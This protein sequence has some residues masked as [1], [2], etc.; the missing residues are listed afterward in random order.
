MA[1]K[2]RVGLLVG[3]ELIRSSRAE[4][5]RA[6]TDLDVVWQ[7]DSGI[8]AMT[9]LTE[10]TV[11]VILVD[12]RIRGMSGTEFIQRYLRRYLGTE[13]QVP[14]FV[15]T[16]PFPSPE[17]A[18]AAVRAGASDFVT[19]E[20]SAEELLAAMRGAVTGDTSTQFAELT[21]FFQSIGVVAGSHPR[22]HL[23]LGE[24]P[25][26][27]AKAFTLL[28]E[29]VPESELAAALGIPAMTVRAT[30]AS[31]MRGLGLATKA[32]LALAVYEAGRL[33]VAEDTELSNSLELESGD[34]S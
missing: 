34:Q 29:A 28:S 15:L 12:V 14:K 26:R 24:L 17:L 1:A 5:F 22:W 7:G 2:L 16:A 23:R 32:Q 31:L 11:D 9:D 27:E 8:A 6:T 33:E 21:E 13:H 20:D 18:I 19:E 3:D 25:E 10:V 30:L 4:L